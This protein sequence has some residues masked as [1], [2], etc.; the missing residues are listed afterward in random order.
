MKILQWT[1]ENGCP[2]V[3]DADERWY[4]KQKPKL[5]FVLDQFPDVEKVPKKKKKK[6]QEKRNQSAGKKTK[7]IHK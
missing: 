2:C 3:V 7:K 5:A 6:T 1:L 4:I